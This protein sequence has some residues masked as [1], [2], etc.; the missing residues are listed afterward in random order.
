MNSSNEPKGYS[1]NLTNQQ[2]SVKSYLG[3][4]LHQRRTCLWKLSSHRRNI[5]MGIKKKEAEK[6][7]QI[8][9]HTKKYRNANSSHHLH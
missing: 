1:R 2:E 4:K 6:K 5:G 9:L 7:N 3:V 8:W